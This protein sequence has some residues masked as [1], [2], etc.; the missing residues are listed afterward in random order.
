MFLYNSKVEEIE[1]HI[2]PAEQKFEHIRKT[3]GLFLGPVLFLVFLLMPMSGLSSAAHRLSAILV[4][5]MVWWITEPVPIPVTA[6]LG[7]T[8]CVIFGVGTMK[9]I[10]A[11][12][13]DPI[14]F[15]FIGSFI[16][17]RAMM[18]HG[19]DR[20]F[21]FYILSIPGIGKSSTLILFTFGLLGVVISMWVSNTA[22]TAMLYPIGLGILNTIAHLQSKNIKKLKYSTGLMLIIAY[23]AS[24]GGIGTPVGT[25]PN[26]IGIGL[27]RQLLGK[28]ITFFR[29]MLFA[30]PIVLIMYVVLFVLIKLLYPAEFKKLSGINEFVA[31]EKKSMAR[32]SRGEIN[33]LIAFLITVLL[34]IFPGFIAIIF[35]SDAGVCR[36]WEAHIPEG[37]AAIIGVIIIFILPVNW[38]ERKGTISWKQAVDI[39]WGTILLFGGGLSLGSLMFSTGLAENVGRGILELTGARSLFAITAI[40]IFLAIIT[41]ELTSN[42]ASA[43]MIIPIMISLSIAAGVNPLVPALG[44]C[45]GASYG[46]MLPVST[47][48]NAIIYGSGMVPITRMIRTGIIFDFLGFLIIL[49]GVFLLLPLLG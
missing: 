21:A 22:T 47:P 17:A 3:V 36:W 35:G 46:F 43:N 39:D 16:I 13:A 25:P 2:S 11:P 44:A 8:L 26:L 29:W 31:T 10:F 37:L 34:W 42:T 18:V 1:E 40:S 20:R 33:V 45:L 7:T 9:N 28:N 6:F 14:I 38:K 27:I 32:L 12:F 15:L 49:A 48:P 30:I 24:V 5:V 23:G 41:S 19:L 4:L